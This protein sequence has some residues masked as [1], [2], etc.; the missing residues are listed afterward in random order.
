MSDLAPLLYL[1]TRM[2]VNKIRRV[3]HQPARLLFWLLFVGWFGLFISTRIFRHGQYSM[4][5]PEGALMIYAFVPAVYLVVLGVQIRAGC[6][7]R[8]ASFAYPAD[9]H[10]L[11]GSRLPHT[12]VVFWLQLREAAFSGSRLFFV[13]FFL[14]WNFAT[15]AYGLL[16][17]TAALLAAYAIGFGIRLPVFL[18]QRRWPQVPLA[19]FGIAL[20]AGGIAAILYPVALAFATNNMSVRFVAL[21]TPVFPPGLWIVRA[22]A[23]NLVSLWALVT[24]AV[25]VVVTGSIMASDAYPEIWEASSHLYAV[26]SMAA[27]GRGL[28]N[29][30]AWRK[31]RESDPNNPAPIRER[32]SSVSGEG[33]PVGALAVLWKEWLA[34]RR[35]PGGLRWPVIWFVGTCAVGV[36]VGIW[37]RESDVPVFV[38]LGPLVAIANII[39]VFGSQSTISLSGELRKP[40]WW[41]SRSELRNRLIAWVMGSM[42]R[43][44]PPVIGGLTL[45][46]IA[47]HSWII[48]VAAAPLIVATLFLVQGIGLA[49]YVV[50]PSRNDM[51]G[52]GP[53]LRILVTYVLLGPPAVAWAIG[54]LMT[55]NVEIGIAS[56]L[57]VAIVE[58]WAMVAFAS[59]RLEQNAMAFAAAEE[60]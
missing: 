57:I 36:V 17:A 23:G 33:A 28:W 2:A 31:L 1:E 21:H 50:L 35:L 42:L 53:M 3:L 32:V 16:L 12:L 26:R 22:L 51:R 18:T 24:L 29:R 13:L 55:Q 4:P 44:A 49:A 38:F 54:Q 47:M 56:G 11:F 60:G 43:I 45:A 41:L 58:G 10:F 14:S 37:L 48:A 19:Y 40:I 5:I 9:A 20:V 7:R 27:S 46:G 15:S 8:P 25:G 52:P 30:D 6:T 39:V 34:L 59:L